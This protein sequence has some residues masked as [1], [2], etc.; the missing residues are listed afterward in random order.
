MPVLDLIA[1]SEFSFNV[2]YKVLE[3]LPTDED[4]EHVE[5][6]YDSEKNNP[7]DL[8]K[9]FAMHIIAVNETD[10]GLEIECY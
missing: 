9:L 1:N 10:D 8:Q 5:L 7:V 2:R 3:Y 6:L 4:P